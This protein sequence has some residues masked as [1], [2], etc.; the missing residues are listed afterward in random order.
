MIS[1]GLSITGLSAGFGGKALNENCV[2]C[3][4]VPRSVWQRECVHT[5][6]CVCG[7]GGGGLMLP[8][9]VCPDRFRP[10]AKWNPAFSASARGSGCRSHCAVPRNTR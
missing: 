6:V 3:S 10:P 4:G 2:H 9:P 1:N 7:G 5:H 8:L